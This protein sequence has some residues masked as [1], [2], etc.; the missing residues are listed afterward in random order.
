MNRVEELFN[1]ASGLMNK[2]EEKKTCH[3]TAILAIIGGIVVL[4][5]AIY[6]VYRF[7]KPDYLEDFE[8]EFDDEDFEDDFFEEDCIVEDVFE[9]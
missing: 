5:A 2:K 1:N 6:G 8:G 9:D 3:V 4:A 7:F